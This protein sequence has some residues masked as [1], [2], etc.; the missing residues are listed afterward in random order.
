[1]ANPLNPP[2]A[3][4][5]VPPPLTNLPISDLTTGLPTPYF[6]N[7]CQKMWTAI[8]GAGGLIDQSTFVFL[9]H[10]GGES[11]STTSSGDFPQFVQPSVP[12]QTQSLQA[13][14]TSAILGRLGSLESLILLCLANRGLPLSQLDGPYTVAMLPAVAPTGKTVYVIDAN[15][16]TYL[17]ALVG[18]GA[19][20]T[21]CFFNGVA[22]RSF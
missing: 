9:E 8:Q 5:P 22:W 7:W 3:S 18:G 4:F 15:G 13:Q 1:M 14:Q 17:G 10:G 20:V 2:Q 12:Q 11:S 6:F 16:P 21:P 19:V